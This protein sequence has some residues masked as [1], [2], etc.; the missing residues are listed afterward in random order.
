M[1]LLYRWKYFEEANAKMYR[2]QCMSM[3]MPQAVRLMYPQKSVEAAQAAQRR[4]VLA[5]QDLE[6]T[7]KANVKA[8]L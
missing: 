6:Q 7:K 3:M 1:A 8:A 2:G 4:A 5:G